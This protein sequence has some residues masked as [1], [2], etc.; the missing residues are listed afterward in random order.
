MIDNISKNLGNLLV[1]MH[2]YPNINIGARSCMIVP[3]AAVE[4]SMVRKYKN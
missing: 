1:V 2:V 3:I 4:S